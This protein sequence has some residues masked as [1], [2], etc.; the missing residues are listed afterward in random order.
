MNTAL[1]PIPDL[2][3]SLNWF[4]PALFVAV[5]AVALALF[6]SKTYLADLRSARPRRRGN[7]WVLAGLFL[8]PLIVGAALATPMF[9]ASADTARSNEVALDKWEVELADWAEDTYN[10]TAGTDDIVNLGLGVPTRHYADV[11]ADGTIR[12]VSLRFVGDEAFLL[13]AGVDEDVELPRR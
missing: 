7:F 3:N 4:V 1:T 6:L 12:E 9:V 10:V 8:I 13:D 5:I 2:P 11:V